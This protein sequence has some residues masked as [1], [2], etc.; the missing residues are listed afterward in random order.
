M[1]IANVGGRAALVE[2]HDGVDHAIDIEKVSDG[3]FGPDPQSVWEQWAAFADWAA[4][5]VPDPLAGP[6]L[7][8]GA[9]GA[10]VPRPDQLFA[11]GL[12]YAA[13]AAESHVDLPQEPS[14]FTKFRSSITGP[15]GTVILPAATVDWETE[16]VVVV[17]RTAKQVTPDRAWAHVAGLTLG[18]DLSERTRQLTPPL[19]QFSLGKSY[20]GF[21]P[22][23]P[24]VVTP[25]ELADPDSIELGCSVNDKVMQS[26]STSDL[27]FSVTEL[28]ARLSAVVTLYPGDLI[29]T[30]TPSGVGH[31]RSPRVYL[32]PGDVLETWGAGIG[33]MRHELV[34]APLAVAADG[35]P[36]A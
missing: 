20:P 8:A 18:Q 31:G 21:A 17:G 10:P 30:G 16:L 24:Y 35:G 7:D 19:P 29:F 13:H 25:D 15:S 9:L 3:R 33:R 36:A 22:I 6:V 28:I 34:G 23:G 26:S 4:A 11:I 2:A 14:V 32:Q 1:R 5:R 12:N 27:I